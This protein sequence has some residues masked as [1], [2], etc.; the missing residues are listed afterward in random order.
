MARRPDLTET[1]R[2][3]RA[4][5]LIRTVRSLALFAGGLGLTMREGF[6]SGPERPSLYVVYAGMMGLG[7]VISYAESRAKGKGS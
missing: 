7:P 4:E 1:E 2:E 5:W 3:Q 6:T